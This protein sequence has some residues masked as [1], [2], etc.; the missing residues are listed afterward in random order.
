MAHHPASAQNPGAH[1]PSREPGPVTR[2]TARDTFLLVTHTSGG[3]TGRH[4]TELAQRLTDE[5]V[6]VYLCAPESTSPAEAVITQFGADDRDV[7]ARVI[8]GDDVHEAAH[9]LRTLGITHLHVHNLVGFVQEAPDFFVRLATELDITTD[10]TIHDYQSICPRVHLVG[11]TGKYCGEPQ[12]ESCQRCIDRLGTPFGPTAIGPWRERQARLLSSARKV[13]VPT[14]DVKTRLQR[15]FPEIRTTVRGHPE[16]EHPNPAGAPAVAPTGPRTTPGKRIGVIGA[17]GPHKGSE[18]IHE[19]A[20][21]LH[22]DE[23]DAVIVIVGFTDRD[24]VLREVGNVE[25]L[26]PYREDDLLSTLTTLQLDAIWFPAVMPE[27]YSYTLSAAL[28]LPLPIV[29]FDF[30][31]IAE[32]ARDRK[33]TVLLDPVLM[34]SPTPLARQLARAVESTSPLADGKGT[35]MTA[36]YPSIL[37]DYLTWRE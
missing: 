6:Q 25:I 11:V 36:C 21:R 5:G 3:G 19:V 8:I 29:A 28:T 26:G 12:P 9:T 34:F 20:Q 32:R 30:G 1:S 31:A 4:I 15:H 16:K 35:P 33:N 37:A 7:T 14:V 23:P 27:T 13:F 18:I 24:D 22:E 10:V 2:M 17:I